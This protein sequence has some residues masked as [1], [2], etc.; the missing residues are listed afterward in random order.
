MQ[1]ALIRDIGVETYK[2]NGV[3]AIRD[4]VNKFLDQ[5]NHMIKGEGSAGADLSRAKGLSIIDEAANSS[6]GQ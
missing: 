2:E 6:E 3:F 5:F 1:A 4:M